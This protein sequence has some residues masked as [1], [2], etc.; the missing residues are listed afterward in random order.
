MKGR[1]KEPSTWAGIGI[2][3]HALTLIISS[4]GNDP[5]AWG[6]LLAGIAA[7]VMPEKQGAGSA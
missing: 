7:V 4:G 3:G 5:V 1:L 6:Q 2:I